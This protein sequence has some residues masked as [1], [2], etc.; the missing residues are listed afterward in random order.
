MSWNWFERV[1]LQREKE[2]CFRRPNDLPCP[3]KAKT[4]YHP[5]SRNAMRVP[6]ESFF[7][8]Y[9]NVFHGFDVFVT[10]IW[11]PHSFVS[12]RVG[13]IRIPSCTRPDSGITAVA[14]ILFVTKDIDPYFS[15]LGSGPHS[16][17][18]FLITITLQGGLSTNQVFHVLRP[19]EVARYLST[20]SWPVCW[21][22]WSWT[23]DRPFNWLNK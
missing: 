15:M 2:V 8:L 14:V 17:E 16:V 5:R 6:R 7:S 22:Q 21:W 23:D 12:A 10:I 3:S 18:P 19:S 11:L 4:T 1:E 13:V 9:Q 20:E